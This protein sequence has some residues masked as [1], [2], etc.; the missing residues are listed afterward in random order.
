AFHHARNSAPDAP[1]GRG[2][3]HV[4]H[5]R[6]L[7]V[8]GLDER[9]RRSGPGVRDEYVDSSPCIL[10]GG[11]K[12]VDRRARSDVRRQDEGLTSTKRRRTA[13]FV[14]A[15]RGERD[16]VA[17]GAKPSSDRATDPTTRAGDDSHRFDLRHAQTLPSLDD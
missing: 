14:L 10:Y 7:L 5:L 9:G 2:Q 3:V 1:K 8:G 4:Q 17:I 15:A 6:P 13:Q 11:E 12:L 16:T